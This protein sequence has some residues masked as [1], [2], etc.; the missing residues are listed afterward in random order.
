[1]TDE[2]EIKMTIRQLSKIMYVNNY[3]KLP[4]YIL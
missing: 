2:N 1:M 4:W 3:K